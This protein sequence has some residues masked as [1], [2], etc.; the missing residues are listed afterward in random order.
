MGLGAR[1]TRQWLDDLES[2]LIF[3]LQPPLNDSKRKSRAATRLG[4][5]VCTGDWPPTSA[6]FVD[7]GCALLRPS[8]GPRDGTIVDHWDVEGV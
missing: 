2:L 3:R 5:V 4:T 6:R 8:P 1:L 7:G